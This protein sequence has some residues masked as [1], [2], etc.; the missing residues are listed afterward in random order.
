MQPDRYVFAG[1]ITAW[2]RSNCEDS[3]L[4]VEDY[5]QCLKNLENS[6]PTVVEYT[7]VIQACANYVSRNIDK[8]RESVQRAEALLTE[9]LD[10][11]DTQLRPNILTYA[12]VLKTIAA[13]RRIPD[14]GERAKSVLR[15]MLSD[16]VDVPP[17]ITN[18]VNRCNSRSP[19]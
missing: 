9:M 8:S 18:L 4:K 10:S 6:T 3:M 7:A 17:Y 16:K 2:G 19:V 13:A 1:L 14:R 15:K 5:F 12:A 11:E